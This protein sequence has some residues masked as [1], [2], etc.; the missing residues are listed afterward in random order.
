M[1]A[2]LLLAAMTRRNAARNAVIIVGL[3]YAAETL[4]GLRMHDIFGIIPVDSRDQIVH[5][6]IAILA[7]TAAATTGRGPGLFA[8]PQIQ[9]VLAACG[10]ASRHFGITPRPASSVLG[11]R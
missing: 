3:I 1:L 2:T 9:I 8:R 5:P 10:R 4:L 11:P 6:A 7:L